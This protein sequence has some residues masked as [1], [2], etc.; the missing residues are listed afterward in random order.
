MITTPSPFP[1]IKCSICNLSCPISPQLV[2]KPSTSLLPID[3]CCDTLF[4]PMLIYSLLHTHALSNLHLKAFSPIC[5]SRPASH[6]TPPPP[7]N[8][9]QTPNYDQLSSFPTG[10]YTLYGP[11]FLALSPN[12][13]STGTLLFIPSLIRSPY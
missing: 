6:S 13:P 12:S 11:N 7:F 4:P 3:A 10:S 1:V 2:F 8:D 5:Q 9:D